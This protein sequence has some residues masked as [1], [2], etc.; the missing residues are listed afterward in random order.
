MEI[1]ATLV[2]GS[3]P[4][5]RFTRVRAKRS[6]KECEQEDSHSQVSSHFG[7]WSPDGL[8]NL[9]RAIAKVKTLC[10]EELF[11]TSKSY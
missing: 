8:Q 7:S 3:R 9:Q 5:Q 4:R 2:L 11:I 6:V 1:V 10:I